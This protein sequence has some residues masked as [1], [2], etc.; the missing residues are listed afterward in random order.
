MIVVDASV[1]ANAVGDD[2]DAGRIA[3]RRLREVDEVA[4]PDLL[5]VETV[6]VLQRAWLKGGLSDERFAAAVDDLLALPIRRLPTGPLMPRAF[7]LRANV[8]AYAACYVALAEALGW[9][10]VTA[11][12]R[13]ATAPT[14]ECAV[15]VLTV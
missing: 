8:T 10:L 13:L 9:R 2:E 3:R 12:A 6:A 4:A 11:D 1:I 14:I 15:E 5:D 7:A